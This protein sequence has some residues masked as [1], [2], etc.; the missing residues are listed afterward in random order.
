MKDHDVVAG[1]NH[2]TYWIRV[3]LLM[4]IISTS[5]LPPSPLPHLGS[6]PGPIPAHVGEQPWRLCFVERLCVGGVAVIIGGG[7]VLW[8]DM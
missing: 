5:T 6:S 7:V 3:K 8:T 1:N 4:D 2:D